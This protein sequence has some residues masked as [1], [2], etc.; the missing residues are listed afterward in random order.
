VCEPEHVKFAFIRD[1]GEDERRKPRRDR[2]PLSL[3]CAVLD[4]SRAG[5]YAWHSRARSERASEDEELTEIIRQIHEEHERRLGIDRLVAELA[6]R[7][8]R[9]SPKRVRRL[10]RAAA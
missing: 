4:V 6:K 3:M 10:V 1:M 9:H 7:G 2:I 5:F 8:R